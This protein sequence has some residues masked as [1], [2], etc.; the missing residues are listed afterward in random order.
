MKK[1][2][3]PLTSE[4]QDTAQP[5]I[6]PGQDPDCDDTVQAVEDTHGANIIDNKEVERGAEIPLDRA[7]TNPI[8]VNQ[9]LFVRDTHCICPDL[10]FLADVPNRSIH[11]T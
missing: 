1:H 6:L 3:M 8:M 7:S 4:A 10:F 5:M 2:L 9:S 11:A